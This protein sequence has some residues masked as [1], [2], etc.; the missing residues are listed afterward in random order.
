MV[1]NMDNSEL[2]WTYERDG[3]IYDGEFV[4]SIFAIDHACEKLAER[5][6]DDSPRNGEVFSEDIILIGFVWN[7]DGERNIHVHLPATAE[8]EHYHGDLKEHGTW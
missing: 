7:D 2:I 6:Q 4:S 1:N 8:Y 3:E 5:V